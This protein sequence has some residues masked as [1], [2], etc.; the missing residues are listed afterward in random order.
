M[1][2]LSKIV[3]LSLIGF[4]SNTFAQNCTLTLQGKIIDEHTNEK[5][6]FA[7]VYIQE[8]GQGTLADEEGIFVFRNQCLGAVHLRISH[9]SCEPV[10][11][12]LELKADTI[13]G[14]NMHHHEELM[15]E[16][17]IHGKNEVISTQSSATIDRDLISTNAQ[18][19]LAELLENIAGVSS[20]KTGSTIGKP[21]IHGLVGNRVGIMN[22]GLSQAG[23]QW[24]NDHAPEISPSAAG[25]I[26]VVKGVGSV[27]YDGAN[28]GGIILVEPAAIKH[29]PHLH[30]EINYV[31]QTNGRGHSLNSTLT[32]GKE[33]TGWR[34]GI[35]MQGIGDLKSP[36]YFLSNTGKKEL[37]ANFQWEYANDNTKHQMFWSTYNT[38]NGILLGSQIG[39]LTDL[40]TAL[41][42]EVPFFTKADFAFNI[43]APKQ[44][45]NHHLLKYEFSRSFAKRHKLNFVEGIQLNNRQEFD[46]R[47]GGRSDIA[48][49][50][51]L[52]WSNTASLDFS[53]E[54]SKGIFLKNGLLLN[55][56]NNTNDPTTGILPLIPDYLAFK[57][58]VFSFW[59]REG[60]HFFNELGVRYEHRYLNVVSIDRLTLD[61][62]KIKNHRQHNLTLALGSKYKL[63]KGQINANLGYVVRSPEINE[64]YSFGLHQGVSSIE[65]GSVDLA[66]EKGI[67]TTLGIDYKVFA[68]T[69]LQVLVYHQFIQ[70]FI[71]LQPQTA[72]LL[73][74]R[75]AFPLFLYQ[76][77]NASIK[78][79]DLLFSTDISEKIRWV[80][81]LAFLQGENLNDKVPLVLMP[82]FNLQ[83]DF[84]W[85]VGSFGKLNDLSYVLTA[86]YVARQNNL[87]ANQ[88]FL[89]APKAYFILNTS[90]NTNISITKKVLKLGINA[91][92]I[93]NT[94]Y[95]DYLNRQ[96]YFADERGLNIS[97]YVNYS[98]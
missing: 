84:K 55:Y 17:V 57:T 83:S 44:A 41:L 24:G 21:I 70:D 50:K 30:G 38:E 96:R 22:F 27:M 43:E 58:G 35:N 74:I 79:V 86:K 9:V 89:P 78:G 91:E 6:A 90:I 36:N 68:N 7:N 53:S 80:N 13:L 71:Y 63:K 37:S 20:L 3:F 11:I 31:F 65:I 25:H 52:Q 59:Q 56:T 26:S 76:Q 40:N 2:R 42:A 51:I 32:K 69:Y 73:T 8:T 94:T 60:E 95:R 77:T 14:V 18:M 75:G 1:S 33:K 47:R 62:Y 16:V 46:N 67:K 54:L 19:Q 85:A 66:P 23:Q 29:D 34:V 5:L 72:P 10:V 88:D 61:N 81:K 97:C 39:N 48:A 49:L 64:M 93:L 4:Y 82:P 12:F 92:N 15:T 28:L 98:F 45:V 87:L